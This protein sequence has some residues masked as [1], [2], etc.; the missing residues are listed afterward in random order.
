MSL[1]ESIQS[2]R[3]LRALSRRQ[4]VQLASEI[5][6]FLITKVSRT[7]GHLGPNLGVVE[8]TIAIHR[9]FDSPSDPV[10]FDTGH[11]SYVHK[12]LTGRAAGFD[13][14]RQRGGLSGYPEPAESEH[15]WV[16]NS[17][18]ST[19]LSWAEGLAKGF[20]LRGEQRTVVAVVGDGALT[21]GMAWE[22]L[23]NIAATPGLR[24]VVVVNDN[25]RSYTPTVGGLANHLAG[26]RTDQRYEKTL[27]LI[28]R[29]VN[30]MPLV[31]RPVYDLMHGVKTGIKDVVAPQSM[32]SDLGIKYMGPLD[33][34]DITSLTNHLEQARH[35]GGPVLVHCVTRKGRGFQ[36]AE[37][38]EEDRF[39]AVGRINEITGE[40]LSAS[41]QATWTD[42]F[43]EAMVQVGQRRPDVVAVTAA[44]L[45]PTGLGRFAAAFPDRTFDVG[46]AEQHAIVSAAGMARS[47][48]H[49]VVALYATFLNRAFDQVL[50][51]ASLHGVGLT[52]ALDRAGVTGTDGPSHNGMWDMSL[53]GLVPGLQLAAPRDQARLVAA[54]DRAVEV[55][56]AI[57]VVRYSKERLP[58]E[59]AAVAHV[60]EGLA[61]VDILRRAEGAR[62]LIVGYGQF[63][64]MGL[65][66]AERLGDQ[67][68]PASVADPLWALPVS[69]DLVSLAAGHDLVVTLEDNLVEGG[70]G[71]KL[72]SRLA[73]TGAATRVL[74]FGIPQRFLAHGSRDEVL[75]EIGLTAAK[76]SLQVLGV[77]LSGSE[78]E[79][80][81]GRPA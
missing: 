11:Q 61:R 50:M 43:A 52:I 13:T 42:A 48:L 35:F 3:D 65:G 69:Q 64:G 53:M 58:D 30:R 29:T 7:G 78:L 27:S 45:Y 38:H 79:E 67:G 21:G 40:P 46:I 55:D 37:E 75:E 23:N 28:K 22:A 81:A 6:S 72:R 12:I 70:V 24:L 18:A 39:H 25:G 71:Q 49:P 19:A 63:A 76:T 34:H 2:P 68:V 16:A 56:D 77:V 33:G 36:A 1:V 5:R 26:L 80:T 32:F 9:V 74:T 62:V 54:I 8:L 73:D 14:L 4:L 66:V 20:R 60:G 59:I 57:T 47:G 31:G 10:I 44:M 41:V 51:D 17:H 15:D